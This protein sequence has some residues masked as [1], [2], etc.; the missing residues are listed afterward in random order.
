MANNIVQQQVAI[1][2]RPEDTPSNPFYL[3]P[4]EN[5]SLVLVSPVLSGPHFHSWFR[6]MRMALLSKNKLGFVDGSISIPSKDD[7]TYPA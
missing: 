7:P 3:H 6:S 4:N 1:T 5:P 2:A